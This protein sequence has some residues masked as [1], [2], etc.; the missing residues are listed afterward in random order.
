MVLGYWKLAVPKEEG[1]AVH[2]AW[3]FTNGGKV[4]HMFWGVSYTRD[5]K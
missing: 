4:G 1:D 3:Q 5:V 2:Q